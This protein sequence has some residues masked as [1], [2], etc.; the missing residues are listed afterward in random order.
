MR[1]V[2]EQLGKIGI[3]PVIKIDD[4]E[5]AVPLA[6]ALKDGGIPCAEVTF[7]TAQ[8]EEAIRRMAAE[9]PD[10][11]VGAGTVLNAE[12]ADKAISAGA[13]FVVSPGLNP[14]VV[15][16]CLEKGVPVV[17]GCAT[18]SDM[19]RAMGLGLDVVK[20]FPAEQCGGLD[21]IKAVSAPY[22]G[23]RFIPT[24]GVNPSNIRKYL[25][26]DRVVACGGSWMVP[27]DLISKKDFAAITRLCV[28][29]MGNALELRLK[30]LDV[31][32]PGGTSGRLSISS[33][34]PVRAEAWLRRL[35][36][37]PFGEADPG[38]RGPAPFARLSGLDVEWVGA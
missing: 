1:E 31:A 18:P 13:A 26:F 19:E 30:A 7:R 35:G 28:E 34:D 11:L 16:R 4:V 27:T 22:A 8:G 20:F 17:P 24:G 5:K 15:L 29:A 33:A 38:G 9:V 21:Y 6:R 14:D 10:V 23:L 2:I 12:Q 25:A 37:A 32:I 36:A 3:V